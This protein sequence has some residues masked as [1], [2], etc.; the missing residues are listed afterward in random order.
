MILRWLAL[1]GFLLLMGLPAHVS[2]AQSS[3]AQ[4]SHTQGSDTQGSHTRAADA[5]ALVIDPLAVARALTRSCSAPFDLLVQPLLDY[6][7]TWGGRDEDAALIADARETL[8]RLGITD[9]TLFDG[10]TLSWCPLERVNGMAPRFDRVLLNPAYKA[11]PVDLVALLGH[12]MV[13]IRQYREMGEEAFRCRYGQ[14]IANGRGM[15][16]ANPLER[17]AYEEED[18]IR[19]RLTHELDR[20]PTA[21]DG[22]ALARCRSGEGAC[23]L[24]SPRPVG[25][26]CACPSE[27]GLS[28]GTVY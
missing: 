21:A 1:A 25:S 5:P 14:D 18:R 11:R 10:V 7:D 28:P 22:G 15:Q 8:I 20:A 3:H 4:G 24:P 2:Y 17:D 9:A 19:A 27:I 13:H 23:F 26:A 12:E 16:R 6:C